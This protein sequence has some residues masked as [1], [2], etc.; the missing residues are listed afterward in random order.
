[1]EWYWKAQARNAQDAR[2]EPEAS[3]A[4]S[5]EDEL[6]PVKYYAEYNEDCSPG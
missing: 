5:E 1:M 4:D 2:V 3:F 6:L